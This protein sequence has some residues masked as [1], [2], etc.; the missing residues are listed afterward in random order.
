MMAKY[1]FKRLLMMIFVIVFSA[2]LI[3]TI[4][5]FVPGDPAKTILG[6]SATVVQLEAKRQELGLNDPYVVQL[7]HFMN[8]LFLHF[9][10]GTSYTRNQ[11]VMGLIM[12]RL[13][14]TMLIGFT[15]VVLGTILGVLFGIMAATHQGKIRD[16][17]GLFVAMVGMAVPPFWLAL[18]LAV[19]FSLKLHWLP[20]FGVGSWKNYVIPIF[21]ASIGGI[22]IVTRQTRSSVLETLRADFVQSARA[23]GA[24][25]RRITYRH[26]LPNALIPVITVT[27]FAF[28]VVLTS[29]I[30]IEMVFSIP[31]IGLLLMNGINGRDYPVVQGTVVFLSFVTTVVMLLTDLAYAVVDPRIKAQ[32]QGTAR[33]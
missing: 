17:V 14:R 21:C 33:I 11:P 24:S 30:I 31:G 26:M 20:S 16:G 2:F 4:M 1:I 15:S 13:P 28:A 3:F 19:L 25:E 10:F 9:D 22:G 7:G 27:G 18:E 6:P 32:Y 12:N 23:K 29:L 5:Y 8:R